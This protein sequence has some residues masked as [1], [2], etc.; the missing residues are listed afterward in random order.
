[1]SQQPWP[2]AQW[3]AP[4]PAQQWQPAWQPP[5]QWQQW[6]PVSH[7]TPIH[8]YQPP[9][10]RR[11]SGPR[12]V[13]LAL[14]GVIVV[15]GFLIGLASYLRSS[16]RVVADPWSLPTVP[17][18]T[19]P[20][21]PT[22]QPSPTPRPPEVD[23][24]EPDSYPSDLPAPQT[25]SEAEEWMQD[26]LLY[27]ESIKVPVPCTVE[28]ASARATPAQIEAH[29]NDLTA[30][31]WTVWDPPL[32]RAGFELPRP[33]VT[34]FSSPITTKC[35]KLE[36]INAV[37]CGS[38]QRIYYHVDILTTLPSSVRRAPFA[39]DAVVA[40]EFGHAVQARSGILISESAWEERESTSESKGLELSRRLEMQADCLAGMFANAV[41]DA[42]DL[43]AAELKSLQ[44]LFYNFGD[45]VLSGDP[46]YIASHGSGTARMRWFTVGLE[47]DQ[48]A[49]CDSFNAR[50]TQVR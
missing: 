34:V 36:D 47:T 33:P 42:N 13:F 32:A 48:L 15:L 28:P 19:T 46:D 7:P 41:A 21:D 14:M 22:P 30:C 16:D 35:G 43:R 44:T 18:E 31:L 5:Q 39:A 17:Y 37:Y 27:A 49:S 24:P 38:D 11:G 4:Q 40:H 26:N 12:N 45:D 8:P 10:R 20:V 6:Q 3:P 50:A 9:R 25:Y 29:L 1:M 23:V 2:S